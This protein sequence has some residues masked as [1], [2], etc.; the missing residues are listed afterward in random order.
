MKIINSTSGIVSWFCFNHLDAFKLIALN[1]GD[2]D[3]NGKEEY[4]PPYNADGFYAVRFTYQ[5][6]G[7]ELAIGTVGLKGSISLKETKGRYYIDV[8]ES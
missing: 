3:K 8:T 7:T 5:G 2:L 4:D 1:S 6:G